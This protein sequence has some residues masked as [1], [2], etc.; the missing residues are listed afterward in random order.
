MTQSKNSLAIQLRP[1]DGPKDPQSS[2]ANV[3][4]F[5]GAVWHYT[6]QCDGDLPL[7]QI[8][9]TPTTGAE[10][11]EIA[12]YPEL[13][14]G[15]DA[16]PDRAATHL[17]LQIQDDDSQA[18]AV[19]D[20]EGHNLSQPPAAVAPHLAAT[21][22]YP[23]QWNLWSIDLRNYSQANLATLA[24]RSHVDHGTGWLQ[25]RTRTAPEPAELDR[26]QRVRTTRGTH[27][28]RGFSRGNVLPLTCLPH[29]MNFLTPMTDARTRQWVYT[30]HG[31]PH[32]A[33]Q[34]LAISHQPS[35]WIG[36]R[37]SMHLMPYLGQPVLDPQQR[38][39]RFRH[40]DE[41]AQPDLYRV[42]LEN[43]IVLATTP[44][45]R[46]AVV[47][48]D[49]PTD[50]GITVDQTFPGYLQ[51][52]TT[53]AEGVS[54]HGWAIGNV[55]RPSE[56]SEP[57]IFFVGLVPEGGSIAPAQE[58]DGSERPYA[59][60][61]ALPAGKHEIFLATSFIS[62]EQAWHNLE[63]ELS[64]KTFAQVQEAAHREWL[65]EL[66]KLE[67]DGVSDTIQDIA[68]SSL[69][70][71]LCY[72]NVA[73]E[74]RGTAEEPEMV[75]AAISKLLLR[76]HSDVGTGCEVLPGELYVNNGYWDTYRTCWPAFHLLY[77]E[78]AP[79]LLGGL[80]QLFRDSSWMGR[81]SAPGFINCMVGTSS[82]VIFA[83]AAAHRINFDQHAAY[84]SALRNAM[85]PADSQVVGRK[86]N[87]F[88][89][90]QPWVDTSQHEG[91]SW[92][93]E[94]C[95]NDVG[96]SRWAERL[97]QETTDES[98]RADRQAEDF[99]FAN[100]AATW[101][102]LFQAESG[103]IVGRSKSGQ[104]LQEAADLNP[105]IWGGDYTETNG[106]GMAFSSVFDGAAL[107]Q[108]HG[109]PAA[110]GEKLD[111]YFQDPEKCL[112]EQRGTYGE[113]LH[114]MREA[115]AIGMGQFALS[116]QP[117]HHV[118][119]MY[120]H[121]D[122]PDR[123]AEVLHDSFTRLFNGGEIGQGWP[124]DE[125]N[126]EFSAWWLFVALGLYPLDVSSGEF[127]ITPPQVG[128]F[129]WTRADG[130]TLAMQTSGSGI[131]IRRVTV[132]GQ[133]REQPV[134][135]VE[136]LHQNFEMLVELSAEPCNWGQGSHPSSLE[137]SEYRRDALFQARVQSGV[138]QTEA[139]I[140]DVG[141]SLVELPAG[142]EVLLELGATASP[143]VL[144]VTGDAPVE[145]KVELRRNG[146][147]VPGI[148]RT[149]TFH[150]ENETRVLP[151]D[152]AGVEIDALR[153]VCPNGGQLRQLELY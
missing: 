2:T 130:T 96:I 95:V 99:Y 21:I 57:R 40:E 7:T 123:A 42:E 150:W 65:T 139:L 48:L 135:T 44:T 55:D 82:D 97:A 59:A 151:L 120:L 113:I 134:V 121:S 30:W 25:V 64:G 80:L 75:H 28:R 83:D 136:E 39:L 5:D 19:I 137:V 147:W 56:P 38:A 118:P 35:P 92:T 52:Q 18:I 119:F 145:I 47:Q 94:G 133:I 76:A 88:A 86:G 143:Q 46:G 74:N 103:F 112:W 111:A 69:Y 106:W 138:A 9:D 81:W 36:D 49:L 68:Y 23:E 107:A 17:S 43:G 13:M 124:G 144:T 50:G 84:L 128:S 152:N 70:R 77:P 10:I 78:K 73:H 91:L 141:D 98:V 93:L 34:G 114:E 27:N 62:V 105:R 14:Q 61:I 15:A 53:D 20:R 71:L 104:W 125:D 8:L 45:V 100:R 16:V 101:R 122:R 108:M 31:D 24:L 67:I 26:V 148:E 37:C 3:G 1:D 129:R 63:L 142:Q 116:N 6:L 66:N 85:T 117:A 153:L 41:T 54:F 102:N 33:L 12:I 132:N 149:V 72:P 109:G 131:Y 11:L 146:Q 90:F 4:L 79:T 110:L 22:L 60:H 29:G 115:R 51:C 32:P 127:V 126:G 140:D 58:N 87:A 89:R